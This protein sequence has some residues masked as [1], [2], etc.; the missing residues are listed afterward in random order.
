V[1]RTFC[2][3]TITVTVLSEGTIPDDMD[4]AQIV[5]ADAFVVDW[6]TDLEFL[7]GKQMADALV[8]ARSEPEI[9]ELTDDG[10]DLDDE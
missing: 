7:S 6:E 4:L 9:F 8:K 10:E 1:P 3:T 2:K 5:S